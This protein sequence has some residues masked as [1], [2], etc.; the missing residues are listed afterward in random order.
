MV[1]TRWN[2]GFYC[3]LP[4]EGPLG[5]VDSSI[6]L[7]GRP[8]IKVFQYRLQ[9]SNLLLVLVVEVFAVIANLPQ[10]RH[11]EQELCKVTR[12]SQRRQWNGVTLFYTR[13]DSL[14]TTLVVI[15]QSLV[16][17]A[18]TAYKRLSSWEKCAGTNIGQ[19]SFLHRLSI[20]DWCLSVYEIAT[21][22]VAFPRLTY[23]WQGN[24]CHVWTVIVIL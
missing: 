15:V 20:N 1:L 12:T 8:A 4:A 9:L 6:Y 11:V 21:L 18:G 17:T 2:E 16:R 10:A 19:L 13:Y 5:A 23:T 14:S 7:F 22:V 3:I 24:E